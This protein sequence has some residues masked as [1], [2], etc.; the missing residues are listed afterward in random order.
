MDSDVSSVCMGSKVTGLDIGALIIRIG[1]GVY[2]TYNYN[3]EPLKPY[4]FH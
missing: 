3:K 2:Y 1:F 4:S